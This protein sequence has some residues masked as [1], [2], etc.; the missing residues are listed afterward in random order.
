MKQRF[1]TILFGLCLL[2]GALTQVGRLVAQS[3]DV[4]PIERVQITGSDVSSVPTIHLQVYGRDAQGAALSF[5]DT[6]VTIQA[7]GVP[8]G[9]ITYGGEQRV[10][11]FTLFLIDIPAGVSAQLPALQNAI[12]AYASPE[13]MME[14]VDAVAVYQV[15]ASEAVHLLEPTQFHNA[16]RNLFANALQPETGLT[17]LF[18]STVNVLEQ[19]LSLRPNPDMV[20]SIVLMTD[21]TD[22]VSES[23]AG[24]L[25]RLAREQGIA[26]HTIWLQNENLSENAGLFGQNYLTE[27][28]ADTGGMAA[29]LDNTA[30]L[31]RIW[32]RIGSFRDQARISYTATGLVPGDT[33]VTLALANQPEI[34]AETAVSI[35]D[36][37]PSVVIDLPAESR[38]LSLP[39][40]DDPVALRLN[41]TLS[42]LDG[43]ERTI[44][45]AQVFVNG[46]PVEVDAE[47]IS[48]IDF[49]TDQLVYG[50][51][52]VAVA[53]LDDQGITARS[54]EIVLTVNEGPREIPAALRGGSL[55]SLG[56]TILLITAVL[57]IP[58][59]IWFLAWR[60]GWL[61]GL[62]GLMPRGG[63]RLR[64]S[65]P[66]VVITDE[67]DSYTVSTQPIAYLEVLESQSQVPPNFP[68]QSMTVKIGRSPAQADI[69]FEQD[70]TVSRLHATLMLE[71]AQYRIFDQKSTSGSWVNERQVPEYGVQ[72]R[73][74]DEIHLGAVH[75]RF[76]QM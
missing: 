13:V 9:P 60:M 20:T 59:I 4:A 72:L 66:Q 2:T 53:V 64:T 36:N 58:L 63:R 27:L 34:Q 29:Q 56:R 22:S 21:G 39:N 31:S 57:G 52:S 14:Q 12:Q 47:A 35:P 40:L 48:Q 61:S 55:G 73:D 50:N 37:L 41:T 75:L 32:Q 30:A 42:W 44:E 43:Q 15:G 1:W 68:L 3:E 19:A 8:A 18:D 74:G 76:R 49:E 17:A 69:A 23:G 70:V 25:V 65:S 46:A 10:G 62:G 67:N 26:I 54:P 7:N 45:A 16:V 24:E 71:G 6:D 33:A 38:T 11:T 51:N 5:A 28:A